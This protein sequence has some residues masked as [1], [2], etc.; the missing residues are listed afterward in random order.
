MRKIFLYYLAFALLVFHRLL[1][2]SV[3]ITLPE[4]IS[5]FFIV[6]SSLLFIMK[7]ILD[8]YKPYQLVFILLLTTLSS[9]VY[10]I[11][12]ISFILTT[13]LAIISIKDINIKTVLKIDIVLKSLSLIFHAAI[14]ALD[15]FTD[16]APVYEQIEETTKGISS[17]L[18]FSNQNT[19]GLFATWLAIDLI[20]LKD[21]P[22]VRNF[23]LPTLIV[24]IAFFITKSRTPFYSY[25]IF[26]ALQF[27]R[28]EKIINIIQKL[29]YPVCIAISIYIVKFLNV[30]GTLFN[31]FNNMF[32][33]RIWYSIQAFNSTNLQIFPNANNAKLFS[34]FVIDNFYI[35]CFVFYG[36]IT[37]ILF[38]IP[39]LL[40]PKKG[41]L[42]E[43]RVS[44][45][46]SL[47]LFFESAIA[48][49][50]FGAPYLIIASAIAN[51]ET[52]NE[53]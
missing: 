19:T 45:I 46:T 36:L 49:V 4:T 28:N 16:F 35:R 32:S 29:V 27:L 6:S 1:Q 43:K 34:S 9:Y 8:R 23:I 37:I 24:I 18:Y 39:H 42:Q 53:K 12:S 3:F 14:F 52:K 31:V 17:T 13:F 40:L 2:S 25:L 50:S 48:N 44:I 41:A 26:L 47:Y 33:G 30:N 51:R 10:Y 22:K 5:H 38:Y 15:Y 11:T 20:C 7:I 21:N